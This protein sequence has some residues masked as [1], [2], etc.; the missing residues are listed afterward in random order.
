MTRRRAAACWRP[1]GSPT[2]HHC[3][4][5]R[6]PDPRAAAVRLARADGRRGPG[7]RL[8]RAAGR[9][10]R[11]G[12]AGAR[13]HGGDRRAAGRGRAVAVVAATNQQRGRHRGHPSRVDVPHRRILHHG[14]PGPVRR[15]DRVRLAVVHSGLTSANRDQSS[16]MDCQARTSASFSLALSPAAAWASAASRASAWA[17]ARSRPADATHSARA[18]VKRVWASSTGSPG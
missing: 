2:I 5:R 16:C 10:R 6:P 11:V 1:P 9:R 17:R 3:R 14:D 18:R 7:A 12:A 8:A 13:A 15:H 4:C